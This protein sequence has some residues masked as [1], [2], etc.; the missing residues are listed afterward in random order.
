MFQ[1]VNYLGDADIESFD[2]DGVRHYPVATDKVYPSIT[3]ITS[4]K[5]KKVIE[6][7]RN[8]VGEDEANRISKKATTRGTKFHEI[9]QNYLEN[10]E[11]IKEDY[12]PLIWFM[13]HH[14]KPYLNNIGMIHAIE[15]A[16]Y[17]HQLQV[18]GRVDC[19]AEYDGGL[20][21]IDFKTA[22]KIKPEKWIQNYFVQEMFYGCAYYEMTGIP[23]QKLITI[24]VTPSGD[25]KVFDK[26]DKMHY[27]KLLSEYIKE[28]KDN[29][30]IKY[31]N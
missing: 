21:I 3:S 4:F 7:W 24:M 17:S 5:T 23:I 16:L 18:A 26:R 2:I 10:K 14:A 20:A 25:V 11:L 8:R 30:E 6:E 12:D 1:H 27:I 9:C 13:F 15:R 29:K 19:I 22:E 28:F 31:G